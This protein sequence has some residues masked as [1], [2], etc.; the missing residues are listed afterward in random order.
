MVL[1][2]FC[3]K[4]IFPQREIISLELAGSTIIK[5]LLNKYIEYVFCRAGSY[6]DKAEKMISKSILKTVRLENGMLTEPI[7]NLPDYYKLRVIVDFISG[8]TDKYALS[9]YQV[10]DGQKNH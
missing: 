9:H 1:K 3:R 7:D 10:L 5:G 2:N 8:M 6:S 4:Y